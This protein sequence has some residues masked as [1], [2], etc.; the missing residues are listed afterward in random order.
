MCWLTKKRYAGQS[1]VALCP[2]KCPG[3]RPHRC[4]LADAVAAEKSY[5]FTIPDRQ[6]DT[7]QDMAFTIPTMEAGDRKYRGNGHAVLPR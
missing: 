7:L 3:N 2:A 1:D 6:I 4:G 5:K